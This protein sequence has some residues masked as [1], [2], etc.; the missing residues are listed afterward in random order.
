MADSETSTTGLLDPA[1]LARIR[2][3]EL[4]AEPSEP[5]LALPELFGTLTSAIWAEVGAGARPRATRARDVGSV[6]RDVQRLYLNLLI[7]M[8]VAPASGTPE[9]SRA[10]ARATLIGLATDLDRVLV[11]PRPDLD[12]NTRAHLADARDRIRRALDAQMIQ[13]TSSR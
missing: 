6:R 5:T 4:R 9:D 1:V 7:Q 11:V 10:L 12:A 8:A 3:A 13:T 2:D